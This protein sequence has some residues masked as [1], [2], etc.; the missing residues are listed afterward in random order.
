LKESGYVNDE[1][2]ELLCASL[3]QFFQQLQPQV[4]EMLP[5]KSEALDQ[6]FSLILKELSAVDPLLAYK[7]SERHS[8][9][10]IQKLTTNWLDLFKTFGFE[11]NEDDKD[12]QLL[13]GFAESQ[14]AK[15]I[16]ELLSDL[17][18]DI[19]TVAA[20]TGKKGLKE[21]ELYFK[22]QDSKRRKDAQTMAEDIAEFLPKKTQHSKEE[23]KSNSVAESK[24]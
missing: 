23:P 13:R 21:I 5:D 19:L 15:L 11:I 20:R 24:S 7:I 9:N 16:D 14:K 18:K 17:R 12:I 3:P 4:A 1:Q 10:P 6:E 8:I 2:A 22:E